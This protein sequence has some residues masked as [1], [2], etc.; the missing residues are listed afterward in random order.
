MLLGEDREIAPPLGMRIRGKAGQVFECAKHERRRTTEGK[1]ITLSVWRAIC[2]GCDAPLE[3]KSRI[4]A[5]EIYL[6]PT[7]CPRCGRDT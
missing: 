2:S 7:C 4:A 6:F 5:I 3:F 1:E